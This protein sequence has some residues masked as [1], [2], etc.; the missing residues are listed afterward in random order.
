MKP[1]QAPARRSLV[2]GWL[3]AAVVS[4]NAQTADVPDIP[5]ISFEPIR[6]HLSFLADDRLEGRGTGTRGYQ[7]AADDVVKQFRSLGLAPAFGRSYSQTVALRHAEAIPRDTFLTLR[8]GQDLRR[9]AFG[10]DFVSSGDLHRAS[11]SLNAPVV[12]VGDGV[13][14]P[15]AGY[16]DYAAVN[17]RGK[18]VAIVL[19]TAPRLSASQWAYFGS[20]DIRIEAA[21]SHG[22]VGLLFLSAD[23][24]FPWERNLQ[25]SRQGLTSAADASGKPLE[26]SRPL[27]TAVLRYEASRDMFSMASTDY[28][29][30]LARH[31]DGQIPAME[32]PVTLHIQVR[33]RHSRMAS[34]NVGAVLAGRD[35]T[36]KSEFVVLTAHLDHVGRG[37]A[38]AGDDIYNGAI[39]DASGVAA[40]LAMAEA[41]AASPA[42]PRRSLLF[43]ATTGEEID[44]LGAK[45][46]VAN[47][48]VPLRTIV[49]VINGDGPTLM[50]FPVSRVNAQG[51]ENSTLGRVAAAVGQR[52]NLEVRQTASRTVSDQAPFVMRG[53][54]PGLWALAEPATP[55]EADVERRWMAEVYHSPKDDLSLSRRFDYG[56]AVTMAQ[57]NLM[58]SWA[59][60]EDRE[61]PQWNPGD[62]FGPMV[63]VASRPQSH[64][65]R[66]CLQADYATR[67]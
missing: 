49:A 39:D 66:E 3:V 7:L 18:I 33:S 63:G 45:F 10:V 48:P 5:A 9:L 53:R 61:R 32:L 2:A 19:R 46:F 34:P 43:L 38:V 36:L 27:A 24:A 41:A 16:D 52:L 51:G 30:L 26:P 57:F 60:A 14:A 62:L 58:V 64:P 21:V 44:M 56:A 20:L 55:A 59:V 50:L 67:A 29:D 17:V 11:V 25:L 15:S 1:M 47:P 28:D 23:N 12:F 31:R 13:S 22:A 35:P 8:R 54:V 4:L 37:R 40:L 42:H 6:N 65:S